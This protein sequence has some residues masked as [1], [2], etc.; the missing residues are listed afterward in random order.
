MVCEVFL[1]DAN[2]VVDPSICYQ[3]LGFGE[4]VWNGYGQAGQG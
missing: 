3:E 2:M 4:S 1:N